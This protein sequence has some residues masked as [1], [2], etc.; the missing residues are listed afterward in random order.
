MEEILN[1]V[2]D[3]Q[4]SSVETQEVNGIETSSNE[5]VTETS[6]NNSEVAEPKQEQSREENSAFAEMRR[7]LEQAEARA[8]QVELNH[9]LARE[10][11]AEY[12]VYSVED[13][14]K[15]YGH[16]GINT[17]EQFK[18]AVER[19]KMIDNG[20]DPD[21]VK[22]VVENDPDVQWARQQRQRQQSEEQAWN[23]FLELKK[24]FDSIKNP[25]DIPQE[26][27]KIEQ[28]KGCTYSD[29]MARYELQ[30]AKQKRN[31]LTKGAKTQQ[32]NIENA[33]SSTGSV[34]GN[35]SSDSAFF[36]REQ[37]QSMSMAEVNKHY[38]AIIES[39]KKW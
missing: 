38:K 31:E 37:V 14:S 18:Q 16:Q 25:E 24:D 8:S 36:T 3:V 34:T 11:G 27:I 35:G 21:V 10:Y 33:S 15:L 13:I 12:G 7:K 32:S 29:A 6:G 1:T 19:K 23:E 5:N 4:E 20:I 17:L 39:Q 28:E 9:N 22:N 30:Q 26:V 2:N